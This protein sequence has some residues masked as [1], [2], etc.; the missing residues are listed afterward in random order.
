MTLESRVRETIQKYGML[1]G[2]EGVIVAVSGGADSVALLFL[3]HGISAEL[4]LRLEVAHLQHGLRGEEARQDA[5]FVARL[6]E[7]LSLPF[8]V[9]EIKLR[10]IKAGKGKG[11]LEAMGREERY[12]FFWSLA[13]E[14]GMQKVATAHTRDDQVETLL[15]WLLRGSGRRGLG[16]MPPIQQMTAEQS[17]PRGRVLVRPLIEASREEII[18]YLGAKGLNYR[19]DRTNLDTG[20][21]RNWIR[22]QLLPQLRER[23][24]RRVDERMAQLADLL[25]EE[26]KILERLARQHLRQALQGENLECGS[27]LKQEKAMQRRLLRL[28]LGSILGDLRGIAFHHVDEALRFISQGPP[29]GRLSILRGWNLVKQYDV[30]RLEKSRRRRQPICYSYPL[31]I[32]GELIIPEAGMKILSSRTLFTPSVNPQDNREAI[33]DMAHLSRTLMVRNFRSGDRFQPLGMHGHKKL[34]DLFIEKKVPLTVRSTLPL[35]L[36][37]DEILWIPRF[38]RSDVAKIGPK[39]RDVLRVRLEIYNG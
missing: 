14:R 35:L 27:L 1:S 38:G 15:M 12:R 26:E 9:K 13:E 7:K 36:S 39:T 18:G 20:L 34:K 28:W 30:V 5:L 3:L 23:I 19:T 16:G 4:G 17:A 2:G 29:Q 31:P 32:Q 24:D 21:L 37:G 22:L 8:H 25:R 33:F 11:N 10:A 6:A